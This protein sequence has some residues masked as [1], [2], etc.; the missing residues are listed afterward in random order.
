M[1]RA[2]DAGQ[3]P[4]HSELTP[5][6]RA[7][8][9]VTIEAPT[10]AVQSESWQHTVEWLDSALLQLV[11]TQWRPLIEQ[12]ITRY[13]RRG[14]GATDA[15]AQVIELIATKW[16]RFQILDPSTGQY[17]LGIEQGRQ[18]ASVLRMCQFVIQ[19]HMRR[20]WRW[21]SRLTSLDDIVSDNVGAL[22][23]SPDALAVLERDE[24]Q[25]LV[26]A[27]IATMPR[28]TARIAAARFLE[29][30][31]NE[32]IAARY[33]VTQETVAVALSIA[34]RLLRAVLRERGIEC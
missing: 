3:V 34:R 32:E 7:A 5:L 13:L 27:A 12:E 10:F 21:D 15:I 29:G 30:M 4:V 1:L 26:E 24:L 20:S 16:T 8:A 19:N 25:A 31:T 17:T 14:A 2:P 33:H 6:G 9:A 28:G 11:M 22:A 23:A 18:R